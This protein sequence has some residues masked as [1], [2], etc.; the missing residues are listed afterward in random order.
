MPFSSVGPCSVTMVSLIPWGLAVPEWSPR[1]RGALQFHYGPL[2][3]Q[4]PHCVTI[5]PSFQKASNITMVSMVPWG[6]A[7]SQWAPQEGIHRVP[8]FQG[9][10]NSSHQR[11]RTAIPVCPGRFVWEQ[12]LDVQNFECGIQISAFCAWRRMPG[13]YHSKESMD[14]QCLEGR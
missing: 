1:I 14:S 7:V 5:A 10:M 4:G 13:L 8:V 2:V 12:P 9:L 3:P 11:P 6:S